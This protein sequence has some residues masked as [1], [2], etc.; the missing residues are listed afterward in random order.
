MAVEPETRMPEISRF[1]GIIIRM[2]FDEH[3]P[4]HFHAAYAGS[5][6]QIG[7]DPIRLLRGQLPRRALSLVYEW[8]ALHQNELMENWRRLQA[9]QPADS[10]APLE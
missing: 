10:I 8:A 9:D 2:F 7:I 3:G 6:A 4:P 1:F 5:V